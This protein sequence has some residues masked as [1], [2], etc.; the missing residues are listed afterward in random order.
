LK[1]VFNE[2]GKVAYEGVKMR[3]STEVF[4]GEKAEK[5]RKKVT[6]EIG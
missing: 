6:G 2:T 3:I 1:L 5:G 4:N